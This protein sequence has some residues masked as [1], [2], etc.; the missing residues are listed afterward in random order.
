MFK[1][2]NGERL[3]KLMSYLLSFVLFR[4]KNANSF[5]S[6]TKKDLRGL[7]LVYPD[8]STY[9]FNNFESVLTDFLSS[10]AIYIIIFGFISQQLNIIVIFRERK[11]III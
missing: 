5:F 7:N 8:T 10:F 6:E 4:L 11:I 3:V 2:T 1:I 9:I